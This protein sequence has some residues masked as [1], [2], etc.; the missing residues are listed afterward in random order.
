M[1]NAAM[2]F[3]NDDVRILNAALAVWRGAGDH[4]ALSYEEWCRAESL[5]ERLDAAGCEIEVRS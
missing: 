1:K 3:S 4:T 2:S 5:F